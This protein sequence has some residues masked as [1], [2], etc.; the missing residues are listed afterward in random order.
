MT[1]LLS[2]SLIPP[3]FHLSL[4]GIKAALPSRSVANRGCTEE[5]G[6]KKRTAVPRYKSRCPR[7]LLSRENIGSAQSQFSAL[8][9]TAPPRRAALI[10]RNVDPSAQSCDGGVNSLGRWHSWPSSSVLGEIEINSAI[11]A[12][13][14]DEQKEKAFQPVP[15][16]T[17]TSCEKG[18]YIDKLVFISG[19]KK[20]S[21]ARLKFCIK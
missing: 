17:Q 9:R 6:K 4:F 21:H 12:T 2:G 18:S 19:W 1:W 13:E 5:K 14:C 8:S 7:R 10:R 11:A 20:W 15:S 16:V 3:G